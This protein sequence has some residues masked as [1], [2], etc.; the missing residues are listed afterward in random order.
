MNEYSFHHYIMTDFDLT[1]V[2]FLKN[3]GLSEPRRENLAGDASFRRYERVFDG[4]KSYVLMVAPPEKEDSKPFIAVDELLRAHGLH[5]PEIYAADLGVGLLLLED[6]G[7]NLYSRHLLQNPQD[8][9]TIYQE[10]LNALA[11][12][13]TEATLK[14]VDLP[15]YSE[16]VMLD[17][18]LLFTD[19]FAHEIDREEYVKIWKRALSQ[20]SVDNETVVLR[21]YHADN[22]LWLPKESGLNKVGQL[23]FQD[24]LIGHKAY[25]IVSLLEDARRDVSPKTA[26]K[27]LSQYDDEFLKDYYILGAQRNCKIIGIFNRLKKRDGKDNYLKFLPRVW[28]HLRGDLEHPALVE[29]REFLCMSFE[30]ELAA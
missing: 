19:W 16:Q 14:K 26:Q 13:P 27:I 11:S 23:D 4:D 9:L 12:L 10:A 28:A 29:L 22:L 3:F 30:N 2:N 6:M 7:D 15:G 8:E 18:A 21:D 17:E 20:L 5:A 1:I 25:D 24:A